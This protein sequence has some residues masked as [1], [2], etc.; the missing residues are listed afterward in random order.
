MKYINYTYGNDA[1]GDVPKR[2][3]PY[4]EG[5]P[6][7]GRAGE[8]DLGG[9][10]KMLRQD[11]VSQRYCSWIGSRRVPKSVGRREQ[12]CILQLPIQARVDVEETPTACTSATYR[13]ILRSNNSMAMMFILDP[14]RGHKSGRQEGDTK[15]CKDCDQSH[16]IALYTYEGVMKRQSPYCPACRNKRARNKDQD[17]KR[18]RE[19]FPY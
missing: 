17:K 16:P 15:R 7:E 12:R 14:M 18:R 2:E 3:I 1:Q 11:E 4:L 9:I 10:C 6:R 8:D 19:A 13:G 5:A